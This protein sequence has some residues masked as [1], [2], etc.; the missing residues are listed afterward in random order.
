MYIAATC[1]KPILHGKAPCFYVHT[2]T[3]FVHVHVYGMFDT[4]TLSNALDL[5][6]RI[7]ACGQLV[8]CLRGLP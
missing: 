6:Y 4:P 8:Q 3:I 2:K 1:Y 5:L 7:F